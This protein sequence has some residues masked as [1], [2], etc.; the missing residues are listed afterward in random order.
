M[1]S[2]KSFPPIMTEPELVD[3]LRIPEVSKAKDH[4]NVIANL[5]RSQGLPCIH[6]SNNCLYPRAAIDAW[7]C[8]QASKGQKP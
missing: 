7:I 4:G 5:K 6:I 3:Y 8:T 1:D 2:V